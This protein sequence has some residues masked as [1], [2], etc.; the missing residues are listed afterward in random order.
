M[1]KN[2]LNFSISKDNVV[3]TNISTNSDGYNG[4]RIVV[5]VADKQYMSVSYEWEGSEKIPDF[6]MDVMKFMQTSGMKVNEVVVGRE[7]DYKEYSN[8]HVE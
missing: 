8:R 5:K 3:Y 7:D 1:A 2:D 6:V 4:A